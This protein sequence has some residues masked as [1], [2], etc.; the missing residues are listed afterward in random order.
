MT[1]D[2]SIMEKICRIAYEDNYFSVLEISKIVILMKEHTRDFIELFT[3][4]KYIVDEK[5]SDNLHEFSDDITYQSA[6]SGTRDDLINLNSEI[7]TFK[8]KRNLKQTVDFLD[9]F[10]IDLDT[11]VQ[12]IIDLI[13]YCDENKENLDWQISGLGKIQIN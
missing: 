4:V 13:F 6:I 11:L 12:V 2:R 1:I 9:S 10:E 8:S 5:F 3:E 7:K